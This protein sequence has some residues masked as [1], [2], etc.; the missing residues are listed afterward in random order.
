MCPWDRGLPPARRDW[1][2]STRAGRFDRSL[3]G[4]PPEPPSQPR[5]RGPSSATIAPSGNY[6]AW[7]PVG[8]VI[9]ILSGFPRSVQTGVPPALWAADPCAAGRRRH[10]FSARSLHSGSVRAR[11]FAGTNLPVDHLRRHRPRSRV[12]PIS[13]L[14]KRGAPFAPSARQRLGALP[15]SAR[16]HRECRSRLPRL[17]YSSTRTRRATRDTP[18]PISSPGGRPVRV[19][20]SMREDV[21]DALRG[22]SCTS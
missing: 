16:S 14:P 1:K 4:L 5:D 11:T 3:A 12:R 10:P 18:E 6:A 21:G 15:A 9:K 19:R 2:R 20:E 7:G 13:A 22:Y 17:G 8:A